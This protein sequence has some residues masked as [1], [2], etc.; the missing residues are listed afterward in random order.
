MTAIWD[1][2]LRS[3]LLRL[4][5]QGLSSAEIGDKMGMNRNQIIGAC[6]RNGIKLTNHQYTKRR[7]PSVLGELRETD[8]SFIKTI[9][10]NTID[11]HKTKQISLH[12]VGPTFDCRE[13][14]Q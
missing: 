4:A 9:P 14:V 3:W 12:K 13:A 8:R 2:R 1:Y 10:F 5:K 11:S 6:R 7:P